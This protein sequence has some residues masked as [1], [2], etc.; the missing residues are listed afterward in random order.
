[1]GDKA[2]Y[3]DTFK[4]IRQ[5]GSSSINETAL[6]RDDMEKTE[7]FQ[8]K[9]CNISIDVVNKIFYIQLS[10]MCNHNIKLFNKREQA[11]E[12]G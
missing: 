5:E 7:K 11:K 2:N 12:Q 10:L 8:D 1:M 9:Y 3:Y 6:I 4:A